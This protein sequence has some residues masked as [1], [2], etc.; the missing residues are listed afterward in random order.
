MAAKGVTKA[1]TLAELVQ[2]WDLTPADIVTFGDMPNDIDMLR[3]SGHSY[4][5]T[6]G[7]PDAIA[8]AQH[9]A[10]PAV[11]DGGAQVLEGML[12]RLKLGLFGAQH[13]FAAHLPGIEIAMGVRGIG[14]VIIAVHPGHDVATSQ[15]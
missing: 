10:P 7:H 6:G 3:W 8:A 12:A 11:E 5:M 14:E 4:A 9:L 15:R 1:T 2:S 13:Q